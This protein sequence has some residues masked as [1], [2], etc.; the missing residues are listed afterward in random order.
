MSVQ[1]H[2]PPPMKKKKIDFFFSP[3]LQKIIDIIYACRR[4]FRSYL[5]PISRKQCGSRPKKSLLEHIFYSFKIVLIRRIFEV[6]L[7]L[8]LCQRSKSEVKV[9]AYFKIL[10]LSLSSFPFVQSGSY[11]NSFH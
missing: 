6:N 4:G 10:V 5:E 8:I 1:Y 9:I 3:I 7:N 2:P 11:F